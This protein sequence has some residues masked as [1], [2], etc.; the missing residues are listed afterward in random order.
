MAELTNFELKQNPANTTEA[1]DK[2]GDVTYYNTDD[3]SSKKQ[4]ADKYNVD[5]LENIYDNAGFT[6][7]PDVEKTK[8]VSDWSSSNEL[9]NDVTSPRPLEPVT[10]EDKMAAC[11]SRH[12]DVIMTGVKVVL[13]ALYFAYLGYALYY[14]FGSEGSLRLLVCTV[15]GALG[16]MTSHCRNYFQSSRRSDTRDVEANQIHSKPRCTTFLNFVRKI[17]LPIILPCLII[18]G[19]LLFVVL[20]VGV[21]RPRNLVSFAGMAFFVVMSYLLSK[22]RSKIKWR[23]VLWGLT[24]ETTFGLLILRTSWGIAAFRWLGDRATEFL[25]YTVAGAEFVFGDLDYFAFRVLPVVV[26][27]S[28][29]VNMMY[30]L[31]VMQVIIRNLGRLLSNCLGTA[32]TE[33]ISAAGNIFIGMTEAPLMI[34][35]FLPD[36][37]K[38][39]IHAI[40][41]GGFATISGAVMAAYI[42]MNVPANHL[43]S[44]SIMAAP[45][46]LAMSKLVY[47]E[48]EVSKATEAVYNIPKGAERNIIEAA[49]NGASMSIKLVANIAVNILAFIAMLDF[50]NATLVWFGDRVGVDGFTF[51][52]IC[53]YLLWPLAAM[54]GVDQDD[55]GKV[56][57]LIGTKT[58]LNEFVAYSNLKVFIEN[59]HTLDDY[60]HNATVHNQT[61]NMTG[62]WHWV[63]GDVM[64]QDTG[65]TLAGGVISPRSMV[66]ATYALCGFANLSSMGMMLGGLGAM[67][68]ERKPDMTLIVFRAMVTGNVVCFMGACIA[69]LL[70]SGEE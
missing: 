42:N 52:F 32:P 7:D 56:A 8:R 65:A 41:T 14:E 39:E 4:T 53:S 15:L 44:A 1:D 19:F 36:M 68:P 30:Y 69:G 17:R 31:G 35:P 46:A 22:S 18:L 33:S 63:D 58:L 13:L 10:C 16:L 6:S 29:F 57:E 60:I 21:D 12:R 50:L 23:P 25:H 43:L 51:Q 5:D 20:D 62:A 11:F 38:S 59:R 27:F 47:P 28:T 34:R 9:D 64:L 24:L 37:T 66:I 26:Y 70:Y 3:V 49:S 55:C 61:G 40:M 45:A 54:M 48:T 67:A 2:T